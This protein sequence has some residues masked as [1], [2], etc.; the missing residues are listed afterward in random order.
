MK[1][2]E[3]KMICF[4][5]KQKDEFSQDYDSPED[6]KLAFNES[7]EEARTLSSGYDKIFVKLNTLDVSLDRVSTD[8]IL[9][10]YFTSNEET[11]LEEHI[12][13]VMA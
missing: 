3:V 2:Y 8:P 10:Q 6:A 13:P 9:D 1:T 5:G 11:I 7:L 4:L 12:L